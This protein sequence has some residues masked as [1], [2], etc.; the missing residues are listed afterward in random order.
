MTLSD[1]ASITT[2]AAFLVTLISLAFSARKYLSIREKDQKSTRFDIY[3]RLLRIISVGYDNNEGDLKLA[4]Q[5]AYIYELRNFP[6]YSELTS[7]TLNRLRQQ[8][9]NNEPRDTNDPLKDA[10]DDTLN[11]LEN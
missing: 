4:S 6:E 10:I 2:I 7:L 3:H 9:A 8:W 1:A 11:H 5:V